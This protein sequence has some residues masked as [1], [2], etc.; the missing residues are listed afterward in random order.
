MKNSTRTRRGKEDEGDGEDEDDEAGDDHD[1]ENG[2]GR[3]EGITYVFSL[4]AY[5]TGTKYSFVAAAR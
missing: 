2:D 3:H 5:P 1:E 4:I